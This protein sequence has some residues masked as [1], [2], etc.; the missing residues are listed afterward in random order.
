MAKYVVNGPRTYRRI[1]LTAA[2]A[3]LLLGAAAARG[4][5]PEK[6]GPPKK[7]AW[8][9]TLDERLAARFDPG[10]LAEREAEYQAEHE[11]RGRRF[12]NLALE[13]QREMPGPPTAT[14]R[15]D[16]RKTPELFLPGELFD[17]LLS[18]VFA[19]EKESAD[20]QASRSGF[21]Q[22]AAALGL[23]R[24]LWDRL[25]E[26]AAPYLKLFQSEDRQDR[27]TRAIAA[28]GEEE[29]LRNCRARARALEAAE[30]EFGEEAFLRLL[31]E[32][33]APYVRQASLLPSDYQWQAERLR[34]QEGGCR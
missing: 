4:A 19:P 21:E 27:A 3:V 22:R 2:V 17:S 32:G 15:I 9:W 31:Y 1:R 30:A 16:G 18:Q 20:L 8:K 13:E 25:E 33:V 6:A 5:E 29:E 24:D 26:S 7:P 11:A 14:E 23:G 28:K 34:F 12:P 10:A